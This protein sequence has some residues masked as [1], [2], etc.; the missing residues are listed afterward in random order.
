M[1]RSF[2]SLAQLCP[3]VTITVKK[4]IATA[5]L[6]TALM[7]IATKS[8][9]QVLVTLHKETFPNTNNTLLTCPINQSFA[10]NTGSW[11][12]YS[13]NAKATVGCFPAAYAAVTNAVKFVLLSTAGTV[14]ADAYATSP[15]YNLGNA[16]CN[17]KYDI[18]FKLY[19][20]NCIQNDNNAYISL[21]F[22]SNGGSTWTTVWQKTSGQLYATYGVNALPQIWMAIPAQYLT[23][24][25]RYRFKAHSNA[26]NAN[27]MYVFVDEPTVYSF[28]CSDVVSL[29]NLVWMDNN[30][31]GIKESTEAGIP[32]ITVQLKKDNDGDGINDPDFTPLTTITNTTG[33]YS[34][35]NLTA[36][37][38]CVSLLN[39][40]LS[41]RLVAVNAGS[42][43][44]DG[45]NNNNGIQE[46]AGNTIVNG[47]WITLLPQSEPTNDGDGNNGNLTYD[48]A[49]A[50]ITTL[51]ISPVTIAALLNDDVVTISWQTENEVDVLY[52][53][54]QRSDNN[55]QFY[56]IAVTPSSK[57]QNGSAA[58]KVFDE[59]FGLI[60]APAVYYRI[61]ITEKDGSIS[62]SNNIVVKN[63]H[64]AAVAVWPN[65]FVNTVTVTCQS[66]STAQ[67]QIKITDANG[68]LMKLQQQKIAKGINQIPVTQLNTLPK[69]VYWI[70]VIKEGVQIGNQKI[71]K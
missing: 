54:L 49:I 52:Y 5:F 11:Q 60:N 6:A 21:E 9:S 19:T 36:G 20:Y 3:T 32:G 4:I 1:K 48:F 56:P 65:P 63:N 34:F 38:Y 43:D 16:G 51:A 13:T 40:P 42:P 70:T 57:P 61:K 27:N 44:E 14:A 28:A 50:P 12:S 37:K 24:S 58:Y 39:L 17:G 64:L 45:D 66:V 23:A 71:I 15:V 53:E 69:G 7:T 22:S 25:F 46:I 30:K 18:S 31:N 47:G 55:K 67:L 29:G 68:K 33:N 62:Y 8:N 41:L 10:G 59:S 2:T 26:N 35:T